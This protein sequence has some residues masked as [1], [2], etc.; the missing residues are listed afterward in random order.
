MIKQTNPK[1]ALEI[2]LDPIKIESLGMELN[3]V[4]KGLSDFMKKV[5][6]SEKEDETSNNHVEYVTDGSDKGLAHLMIVTDELRKAEWFRE[7][8][9]KLDTW[10]QDKNFKEFFHVGSLME[11]YKL[12]NMWGVDYDTKLTSAREICC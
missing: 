2:E 11:K 1:L 6:L 5:G 3:Y 10:Q 12:N 8:C 7:T 4:M 9:V